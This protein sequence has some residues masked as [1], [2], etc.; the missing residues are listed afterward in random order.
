MVY[1]NGASI[2]YRLVPTKVLQIIVN[3]VI[4]C[5]VGVVFYCI[6]PP[7]TKHIK[8]RVFLMIDIINNKNASNKSSKKI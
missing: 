6:E 3:I 5:V 4:C 7:V 2:L 8:N 1:Y